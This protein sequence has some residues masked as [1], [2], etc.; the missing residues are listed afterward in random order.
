MTV[1]RLGLML[2]IG[3]G[4]PALALENP[5]VA[6]ILAESGTPL[7][8]TG[9]GEMDVRGTEL[10]GLDGNTFGPTDA[11]HWFEVPDGPAHV[12]TF[13]HE[14]DIEYQKAAIVFSEVPPVCGESV[15]MMTVD[16]GMVAFLDRP[17][18]DALSLFGASMSADCNLYSCLIE[19][20]VPD[21]IFAQI[22]RLPD[23]STYPAFSTPYLSGTYPMFLLRDAAGEPT[24]AFVD[25]TGVAGTFEWLTPPACPESQS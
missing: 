22:I 9:V 13:F 16:S 1:A 10:I 23:G 2:T 15:G 3:I 4:S 18:A 19:K 5:S 17:T 21:H 8:A 14:K 11:W 7:V 24:A 25:F 12:V 6:W 20:Q